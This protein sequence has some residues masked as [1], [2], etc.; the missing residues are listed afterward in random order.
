[1]RS[2]CRFAF[3]FVMGGTL[4]SPGLVPSDFPFIIY[5]RAFPP[6]HEFSW[7]ILL[8]SIWMRA[9]SSSDRIFR[10][11]GRPSVSAPQSTA[12]TAAGIQATFICCGQ[13]RLRPLAL[14]LYLW[15]VLWRSR[16]RNE[17]ELIRL[18]SAKPKGGG[19]FFICVE[20]ID[21]TYFFFVCRSQYL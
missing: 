6:T 16:C 2:L 19:Y 3:C 17:R 21:L 4:I 11:L 9:V 8:D 13:V 14:R 5:L 1:M 10:P 12:A 7:K 18:A 15:W 20:S